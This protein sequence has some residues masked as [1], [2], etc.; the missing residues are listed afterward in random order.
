MTTGPTP[1]IQKRSCVVKYNDIIFGN[2]PDFAHV[3]SK[4]RSEALL[5]H[6]QW[7]AELAHTSRVSLH[8]TVYQRKDGWIPRQTTAWL[9]A[10]YCAKTHVSYDTLMSTITKANGDVGTPGLLTARATDNKGVVNLHKLDSATMYRLYCEIPAEHRPHLVV[11]QA[12][13]APRPVK[14]KKGQKPKLPALVN[15]HEMVPIIV[16]EQVTWVGCDA[17]GKWRR[18]VGVDEKSVADKWW[19]NMHP[20]GCITCDTPEESM[21]QDEKWDGEVTSKTTSEA[22][23]SQGPSEEGGSS[24][25]ESMEHPQDTDAVPAPTGG[26]MVGQAPDG[27]ASE[28]DDAVSN[29]FGTDDDSDFSSAEEPAT[30]PSPT[31]PTKQNGAGEQEGEEVFFSPDDI[32]SAM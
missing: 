23:T 18:L 5:R 16:E 25:D 11:Q 12:V 3:P 17:C 19:C 2:V 1:T 4:L 14:L 31:S 20:G 30:A 15:P 28:D 6:R 26:G 27:D 7:E 13:R 24:E 8:R 32:A 22:L 29:L 9:I 21:D 10:Q